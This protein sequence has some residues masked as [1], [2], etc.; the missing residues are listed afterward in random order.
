ML[1]QS[2]QILLLSALQV[3]DDMRAGAVEVRVGMD[4]GCV[5][6]TQMRRRDV[7]KFEP[8]TQRGQG[9][10]TGDQMDLFL[11]GLCT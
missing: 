11:L 3:S 6:I 4:Q 7:Q 10:G 1:V 9:W 5:T 2:L 8:D